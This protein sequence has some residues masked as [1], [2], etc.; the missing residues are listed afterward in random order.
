MNQFSG[1]DVDR[2]RI[3]LARIARLVDRQVSG[4]GMTRT[5]LSVLGTIARLGPLGIS[6]LADIE[7]L[8]PT[9]LSRVLGKLEASGLVV[10]SAAVADRRAVRVQTTPAGRSLQQRLRRQRS[11]LLA[12][13]L[14][15]L[16][17]GQAGQLLAALPALETLAEQLNRPQPVKSQ[18]VKAAR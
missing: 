12:D 10:R 13:R 7:G 11:Q 4:E 6:E 1:E 15:G 8:N 3:A 2:L 5:Q 16:P 9:M 14:T 17:E 18:P